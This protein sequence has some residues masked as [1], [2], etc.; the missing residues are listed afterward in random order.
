MADM[1]N[2]SH[3]RTAVTAAIVAAL[4]A[5]PAAAQTTAPL[6]TQTAQ[7][8]SVRLTLPSVNVTAQKEVQDKQKAPVSVTAVTADTIRAA[9]IVTVSDAALFAPNVYF[10]E[11][12]ARKL[13]TARFRGVSASPANPGVTTFIDG[14]PQF[15]TNSSSLD[16]LDV[17][18]IEF[19]R[20]PQ[21]ALFGRN[22]L[23]GLIN[24]TSARPSNG[25]WT[26]FAELPIANHGGVTVRG[27]ASGRIIADRLSGAV[28]FAHAS[29][30]GYTVN[31]ITDNDLDDRS[32]FSGKGQLLWTPTSAWEARLILSGERARDGDYALQDLGSLRQAPFEAARD[33]E[34]RTDRDIF[35]TTILA[36][37]TRDALVFTS[38]TG[39]VRWTTQDRTDLDY[40]PLSLIT[41]DNTEQDLQFTQE[42]RVATAPD[43][44][45]ALRGGAS[46]S[47]Q[48]GLFFFTQG[49]EQQAVNT[50]SGLPMLPVVVELTSPQAELDD[51]GFG[52]F[53]QGT[54]A[55]ND[56]LNLTAGLRIDYESK[57]A[58]LRTFSDPPFLPGATVEAEESF[59]NVS[60][61]FAATYQWRP[62]T[63]IYATFG[64]GYKAG[65]FN[66][67]SP[68]GLEAYDEE[69][70]WLLEGGVKTSWMDGR[71][72]TNASLFTLSWTDLQLNVP[73]LSLPAQFYISNAG[74]ARSTGVEFEVSGRAAP[75]IDV[76]G[77]LG[78]TSARF[79]D[80][81][82]SNGVSVADNKLANTPGYTFS[83]GAQ[84][85]RE[86]NPSATLYG[87]GELAWYGAFQY[88]DANTAS[89]EAYSIANLRVGVRGRVLF[90]EGWMRNAFD[91]TYIPVAFPYPGF[92]PSGFVGEM[93][94][95]RT[96]GITGGVRF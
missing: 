26:G 30:D 83:L 4:S 90:V 41:R 39:I 42:L 59:A 33:F 45:V 15:N 64:G 55:L 3:L 49:Y 78:V 70:T 77:A 19:V 8:P 52:L 86:L 20:G 85:S 67:A 18:Q 16:L 94:A 87:R 76:F 11:F 46:L 17:E 66:P 74:G 14:V 31:T 24:I 7:D 69:H 27:G 57:S 37:H 84:Y 80:D 22:T 9:G 54:V 72:T 58:D 79:G 75:G 96:F 88:D 23:G 34:G 82:V 71:V 48:A 47:W 50:L 44:P 5:V 93:G 28:S 89:Q 1:S 92:A 2:S 81:A 32:A 95:P 61:Q 56:R 51:A 36:R 10:T 29:R 13:S 73:D 6:P 53:G 60:P 40:T 62:E 65:G 63:M 68:A 38:T 25:A 12:T 43:A 35:S 91:T 21:S